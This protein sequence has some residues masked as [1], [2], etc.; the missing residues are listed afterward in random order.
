MRRLSV[1]VGI[2]GLAWAAILPAGAQSQM[3]LFGK[4]YNVVIEGRDQTFKTADGR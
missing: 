1:T 4:T 2:L 3:K